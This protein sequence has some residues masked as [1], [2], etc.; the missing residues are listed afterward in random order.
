MNTRAIRATCDE[1]DI[2]NHLMG[3][4]RQAERSG[5]SSALMSESAKYVTVAVLVS[6]VSPKGD[7][8]SLSA[9]VVM[10]R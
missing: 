9:S 7:S 4:V 2:A 10:T 5:T 6:S 1:N 3:S 8:M